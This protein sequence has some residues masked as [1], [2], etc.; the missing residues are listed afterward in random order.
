MEKTGFDALSNSQATLGRGADLTGIKFGRWTVQGRGPSKNSQ[1]MWECKCDCGTE[2]LVYG[3][4]LRKRESTSC[5]C[6]RAEQVVKAKTKHGHA[7]NA[8][9][10]PTYRSWESM[11]SRVFSDHYVG[12]QHYKDAGVTVCAEW[13]DF[14]NFLRDMGERPEGTTLD[15]INPFGNYEPSNCRWADAKTQRNNRRDSSPIES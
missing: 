12:K 14:T 5:G 1:I 15:R 4:F 2:K 13:L 9:R 7:R 8:K 6:Y 11:K 10:N 3:S